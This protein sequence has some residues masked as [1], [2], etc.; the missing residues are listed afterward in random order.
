RPSRGRAAAERACP[1]LRGRSA[2]SAPARR[3]PASAPARRDRAR[4]ARAALRACST[5]CLPLRLLEL[6]LYFLRDLG[7]LLEHLDRFVWVGRPFE[8]RPG[9]LEPVEQRLGV[10]E[11]V[12]GAHAVFSCTIRPKASLAMPAWRPCR[13]CRCG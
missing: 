5:L 6:R 2:S 8:A 10:L 4:S 13:L 1:R 3:A 9:L 12:I 11:P 7:Q